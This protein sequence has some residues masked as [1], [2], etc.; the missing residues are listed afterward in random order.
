MIKLMNFKSG[1]PKES[2]TYLAVMFHDGRCIGMSDLRFNAE[3]G[4]WND[5][6]GSGG[7]A[8]EGVKLWA[9]MPKFERREKD[10]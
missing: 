9:E 10:V 8:I 1:K 4:R 2:G 6:D 5:F 3:S 7:Y